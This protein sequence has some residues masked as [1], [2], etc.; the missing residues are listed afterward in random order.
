[1]L[2]KVELIGHLGKDPES[3]TFESGM[4]KTKFTL[5]TNEKY[6]NKQGEKVEETEWHNI[7][8]WGKLAEIA[9]KYL[10]KGDRI[11]ISGKIKTE[12]WEAENG[13]KK[14]MVNIV[15]RDLIML[16]DVKSQNNSQEER[17]EP[18]N[19]EGGLPF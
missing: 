16:S 1:M 18:K 19:N 11:H 10:K 15:G 14:Y 17:F 3:F 6:K 2:N 7:V 13:E 4:Q 8:L 9:G 5:A 12:S